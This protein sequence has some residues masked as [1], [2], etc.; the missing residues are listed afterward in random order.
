MSK[1]T[2]G[3]AEPGFA[4]AGCGPPWAGCGSFHAHALV[5]LDDLCRLEGLSFD[6]RLK[7]LTY[8]G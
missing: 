5:K 6:K 3:W 8:I 2:R 7:F 1:V 4:V